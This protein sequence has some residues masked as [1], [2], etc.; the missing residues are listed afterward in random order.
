M[1]RLLLMLSSGGVP[2]SAL[3]RSRGNSCT[4][5]VT[6]H[7][8]TDDP[9]YGFIAR[10]AR[11]TYSRKTYLMVWLRKQTTTAVAEES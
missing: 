8:N 2:V 3:R 4:N 5:A 10:L 1:P 7:L 11:F 6:F 9:I